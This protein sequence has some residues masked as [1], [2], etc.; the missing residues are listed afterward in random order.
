MLHKLALARIMIKTFGWRWFVFRV[1]YAFRLKSGLMQQQTPIFAWEDKPL[2]VWLRPD[3]P[4]T[5]TDYVK[6]RFDH[7]GKFFFSVLP[8]HA[9]TSD[10]KT[11]LKQAEELLS[12][13]WQLFEHTPA[14]LGFPPDW[15]LNPQTNQRTSATAHWSALGDFAGGDIKFIWEA[16]RF[17]WA[18]LLVRAYAVGKDERYAEAFWHLAEHW[19][20][21]NQPNRGANWKCGQETSFRLM[22]WCFALYGFRESSASTPE[23][24]ARLAAA[25]AISAQRIAANIDYARWQKNNH[26]ISEGVGLFTVGVLFPEFKGA[27]AWLAQGKR[28]IEEE[29][30]RQI[31]PDGAYVQQSM[32]YHRLMLH[33]LAWAARLAA[34]NDVTLTGVL[35]KMA[36]A[37]RFLYDMCDITSGQ[38]P[39]YGANDGALI[40]PLNNCDFTDYRPVL[41]LANAITSGNQLF[42]AG[43][44]DEDLMWLG[45]SAA[46]YNPSMLPTSYPQGTSSGYYTLRGQDSWVFLRCAKYTDRPSHADQLHMDLWWRGLNLAQD[47][48]SYLYNGPGQWNNGLSHTRV[49][50]TITNGE[51]DQMRQASR[52]LWLD[53]P[54]PINDSTILAEA[55][56][57]SLTMLAFTPSPHTPIKAGVGVM[58]NQHVRVVRQTERGVLVADMLKTPMHSPRWILHWLLADYPYQARGGSLVLNTPHGPFY[59]WVATRGYHE[60]T[61]RPASIRLLRAPEEDT[62]G[63]V[64]RY[65]GHKMPAISVVAQSEESGVPA[66]FYT[67]F[68]PQPDCPLRGFGP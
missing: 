33:D 48:G 18:Y 43:P 34:N 26:A 21:H 44:W 24:V 55:E 19:L 25:I 14:V 1:A 37:T 58:S 11:I 30:A 59:M 28:V 17:A 60:T 23:R 62:R 6:W 13:T 67:W 15:H 49:H 32:N 27:A 65:Y 64:S 56:A 39:N 53:W 51:R 29:V 47:A 10:T 2:K 4:S 8:S 5:P 46:P 61:P 20:D 36:L 68:S 9:K 50:N 52:F 31:Y 42:P 35:E 16:S 3:V 7:G 41:G 54:E 38:T 63:W 57:D 45:V 66:A 22:A 12:G 40:L